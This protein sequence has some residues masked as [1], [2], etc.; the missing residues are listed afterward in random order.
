MVLLASSVSSSRLSDFQVLFAQFTRQTHCLLF[1]MADVCLIQHL[2]LLSPAGG[3]SHCSPFSFCL[4]HLSLA[5][6][7]AEKDNGAAR[8]KWFH[9]LAFLGA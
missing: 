5:S 9:V 6:Q 4:K 2:L 1:A 7:G 3:K 8:D